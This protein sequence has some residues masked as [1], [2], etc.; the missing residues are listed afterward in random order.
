VGLMPPSAPIPVAS[1]AAPELTVAV[2]DAA[3]LEHAAAPTL[4]F[5]IE[6][7]TAA[8]VAIR[9]I[10]LDVQLQ[11]AAR[12]RPYDDSEQATLFELFGA[13]R[14]WGTTLRTLLWA[15][16][17]LVVP[18]FTGRTVVDLPVVCSYDLDVAASRYFDALAGGDVP[19][20]LLFSGTIFYAGPAG[21]LQ[22]ARIPWELEAEH[23]LPVAVWRATLDRHFPGTAWVRL[24][25]EAFDALKTYRSRH[26]L[27]SWDATVGALLERADQD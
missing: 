3:P 25:R 11:I 16:S 17:T 14:D 13:P 4:R 24:G 26:G 20:E 2:L 27:I 8:D 10:L 19:L 21:A 9:S 15:R 18:P 22:A 23:R 12:R 5:A 7:G 1:P 6:I